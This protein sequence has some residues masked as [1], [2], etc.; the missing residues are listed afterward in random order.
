[1]NRMPVDAATSPNSHRLSL[2]LIVNALHMR[3]EEGETR[4]RD[5]WKETCGHYV[6]SCME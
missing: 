4:E 5:P 2:G 1:M 3:A 6:S